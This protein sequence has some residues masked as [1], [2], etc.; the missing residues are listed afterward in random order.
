MVLDVE[1]EHLGPSAGHGGGEQ[2]QRVGG[3]A[4][5]DDD[6]VRAGTDEAGDGAAGRASYSAVLTCE[7]YPA[8]RCTLA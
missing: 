7:A 1:E 2:V 3:V 5:E 8:P 4:G 6:V